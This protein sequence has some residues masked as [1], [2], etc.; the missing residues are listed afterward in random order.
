MDPELDVMLQWLQGADARAAAKAELRRRG[1]DVLDPDDLINDVVLRLA[2]AELPADLANPVAYA[3]RSLTLHAMD[4]LRGERVQRRHRAPVPHRHDDDDDPL[5][6]LP[7]DPETDPGV[8]AALASV[9]DDLRRA[10]HRRLAV[11]RVKVWAVAAALTTLTLRVHRDVA[12]PDAAPEPEV[13]SAAKADRWAAL[14]L[15]GER[16]VFP[17]G[18]A[19]RSD[20]VALRKARSRKLQEVERLLLDV[21]ASVLGIDGGSRG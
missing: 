8:E 21:A 1:L 13:G 15:A 7:D 10:L 17:D 20:G 6:D 16:D 9:E 12:V 19:G 4:L 5:L 18:A 14:W 3:R 2:R 11:A